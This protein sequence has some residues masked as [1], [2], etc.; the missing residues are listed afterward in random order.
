MPAN[1]QSKRLLAEET[2]GTRVHYRVT[3][4]SK[5]TRTQTHLTGSY[6]WVFECIERDMLGSQLAERCAWRAIV[7]IGIS[8]RRLLC[9][10]LG[11]STYHIW[12]SCVNI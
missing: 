7:G 9:C 2:K 3:S 1:T 5:H 8:C 4:V 11:T 6:T 12:Y 10:D